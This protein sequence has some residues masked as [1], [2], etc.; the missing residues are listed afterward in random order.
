MTVIGVTN[1]SITLQLLPVAIMQQ[2][3]LILSHTISYDAQNST[4]NFTYDM[5]MDN[6]TFVIENVTTLELLEVYTMY[7][8]SVYPSTVIGDGPVSSLLQRTSEGGK[9]KFKL[10]CSH[11]INHLIFLLLS[12]GLSQSGHQPRDV[13]TLFLRY[14]FTNYFL[15]LLKKVGC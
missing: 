2:N 9:L 3:G 1:T 8:I 10:K 6:T 11:W 12:H 15:L 14:S 5:A 7:N 13:F 4:H